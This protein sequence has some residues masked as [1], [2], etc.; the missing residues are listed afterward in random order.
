MNN[1]R[2]RPVIFLFVLLCGLHAATATGASVPPDKLIA[3]VAGGPQQANWKT[4][5]LAI[6]CNYTWSGNQLTLSGNLTFSDALTMNYPNGLQQFNMEV[7]I[8]DGGGK[9]VMRKPVNIN[10]GFNWNN[11]Y[12]FKAQVTVVV[13]HPALTFYYNGVPA[14]DKDS[15]E[16][17]PFWYDPFSGV[18]W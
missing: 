18:N 5:D 13:E 15:G 4:Q 8:V 17:I 10:T 7:V 12:S 6:A 11:P 2:I 14:G 9:V 1:L 16:G 3:L